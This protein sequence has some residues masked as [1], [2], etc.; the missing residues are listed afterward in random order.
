MTDPRIPDLD[1][2]LRDRIAALPEELAPERDLWPGIRTELDADRMRTIGAPAVRTRGLPV[3]VA[4]VAA[5]TVLVA[6]AVFVANRMSGPADPVVV[7]VGPTGVPSTGTGL[8]DGLASYE[9]SA[10]E[11]S[12]ALGKRA[13]RLDP[14]TL[15]VLERSMRTIDSAISEARAALARDPASPSVRGYVEAVYRQKID[16]LRRANDVASLWEL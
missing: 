3:R 7:V 13:A 6:S 10:E 11:L 4:R 9:R 8:P 15:E 5:A 2:R 1:P 14:A 12:V 16:F